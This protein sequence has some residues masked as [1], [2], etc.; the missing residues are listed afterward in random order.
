[1]ISALL[2]R[3]ANTRAH[4]KH[5]GRTNGLMTKKIVWAEPEQT[6]PKSFSHLTDGELWTLFS[7]RPLLAI[8]DELMRRYDKYAVMGAGRY[9]RRMPYRS[10]LDADDILSFARM[11]LLDAVHSYDITQETSFKTWSF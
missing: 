2:F 9:N 6:D 5:N 4:A 11:G 10:L 1:M 3:R 7:A 8:R